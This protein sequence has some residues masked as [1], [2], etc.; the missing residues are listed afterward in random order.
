MAMPEAPADEPLGLTCHHQLFLSAKWMER[1]VTT[2][3][4]CGHHSHSR[5]SLEFSSD[6]QTAEKAEYP[7]QQYDTSAL[8]SGQV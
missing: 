4:R 1:N 2:R 6:P 8:K 7:H 5:T 3:A